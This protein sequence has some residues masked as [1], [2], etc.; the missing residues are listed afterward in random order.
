M[1]N[2]GDT[3]DVEHQIYHPKESCSSLSK[4][5]LLISSKFPYDQLYGTC[6][7]SF[8][9]WIDLTGLELWRGSFKN[10][11]ENKGKDILHCSSIIHCYINSMEK[12]LV[13]NKF[14]IW[15]FHVYIQLRN[16]NLM[17][18]Q[19]SLRS[20]SDKISD[21]YN[22]YTWNMSSYCCFHFCN[23]NC[24]CNRPATIN[25]MWLIRILFTINL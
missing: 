22:I 17:Q 14:S 4:K 5:T 21:H 2:I 10:I 8:L 23:F 1:V 13:F 25:A 11:C 3:L 15:Y 20:E 9:C 24:I 18:Q 6:I 19:K 12:N 16:A 7:L